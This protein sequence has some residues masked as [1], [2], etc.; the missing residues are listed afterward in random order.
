MGNKSSRTGKYILH[1]ITVS[2]IITAAIVG[3]V[4]VP[5]KH[6]GIHSHQQV[7]Q[8]RANLAD[9]LFEAVV[10]QSKQIVEKDETTPPADAALYALGEAY[11]HHEYDGRIISC[12]NIIL[13]SLSRIF[14]ILS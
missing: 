3:C 6:A 12:Q 14:L 11:A 10:Q 4:S 7:E 9:G 5:D 8:N 13:R 1:Y 2:C